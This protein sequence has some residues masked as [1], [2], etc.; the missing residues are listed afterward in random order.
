MADYEKVYSIDY[1][2][3][4]ALKSLKKLEKV[5]IRIDTRS[6]ELFQKAAAG[7]AFAKVS[8]NAEKA[9]KAV[10]SVAKSTKETAKGTNEFQKSLDK[11]AKKVDKINKRATTESIKTTRRSAK[12][13]AA[14]IEKQSKSLERMMA[15]SKKK[16]SKSWDAITKAANR[17]KQAFE[18]TARAN[19]K[20]MQPRG[21]KRKAKDVRAIG[22][23]AG[24]ARQ[25][26][27]KLAAK[28]TILFSAMAGIRD[29]VTQ[30]KEFDQAATSAAAKFS[31]I[32]PEL[33][34]GTEGFKAFSKEIRTAGLN[35]EH[36]AAA[37]AQAMDFW[38]K[39]GKTSTES[40]AV[41]NDTLSFASA[42]QDASGAMLDVAR[43]GDILSDTLGAF[44]LPAE[45]A[46]Q[47]MESTARVSDTMSAAAN[48][49]NMSAEELFEA[50]TNAGPALTSVGSDIE[51][52]SALLAAMANSGI[53]GSLAGNQLKMVISNLAALT[54]PQ[55][56]MFEKL[57]VSVKDSEGNFKGLTTIIRELNVATAEMGTGDRYEVFAK[58]VGRRAV[59]AFINL[60]A[61]G[62]VNLDEM[63]D[64]LRGAGGETNR[65]A[66]QMRSSLG[67]RIKIATN[68]LREF[69][70]AFLDATG[71]AS[72]FGAALGGIDW[73]TATDQVYSLTAVTQRFFNDISGWASAA[74][75]RLA[76]EFDAYSQSFENTIFNMQEVFE[77]FARGTDREW[78]DTFGHLTA[79]G[80][81]LLS[82]YTNIFEELKAIFYEVVLAFLG[83]TD[84]IEDD[85]YK[86]G[87]SIA[88]D[89]AETVQIISTILGTLVSTW[90]AVFTGLLRV[91]TATLRGIREGFGNLFGGILD[92]AEGDFLRGLAR[93]G[94]ALADLITLPLRS[95]FSGLLKMIS[96]IPGAEALADSLGVDLGYMSEVVSDGFGQLIGP[97]T[98]KAIS[99]S[100]TVEQREDR[101]DIAAPLAPVGGISIPDAF[102][103]PTAPATEYRAPQMIEV[104]GASYAP[105][106]WEGPATFDITGVQTA[107]E[108]ANAPNNEA[109]AKVVDLL[110]DDAKRQDNR[111]A[112]TRA[113]EQAMTKRMAGS[114]TVNQNVTV[115]PTSIKIEAKG[116]TAEDAA[117]AGR[118]AAVEVGKEIQRGVMD[119]IRSEGPAEI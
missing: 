47:L 70:F 61:E 98:E 2:V 78:R 116:V 31:R 29:V 55:T 114:K 46:N 93:V 103:I 40:K 92:M 33:R 39:A 37:V 108:V 1:D 90:G 79:L 109:L 50:F 85:W 52:T 102:D 97:A 53:K 119:G 75:D 118:R 51:E 5:L 89:F 49:A 21:E 32:E 20:A 35:T 100:G 81:A 66:E 26:F 82:A 117:R 88:G 7:E 8:K 72:G 115:G 12:S 3:S 36:S 99:R 54:G 113:F 60:L 15:R 111:A 71:L 69:G 63:A 107:L 48:R 67:A 84:E 24:F 112:E 45:D 38:A 44:K 95:A 110:A 34:P 14:D 68:G 19:A 57:G 18:A 77:G 104:A 80:D 42:N 101:R 41:L 87:D 13:L 65:L 62:K 22:K 25:S 96:K 23:A 16:S 76:T 56:A 11:F 94:V 6:K 4:K 43:A 73:K 64:S 105:E 106:A 74:G 10:A 9:Q 83:G 58:A 86:T 59:P 30:Y 28:A 17:T 91:T 27:A